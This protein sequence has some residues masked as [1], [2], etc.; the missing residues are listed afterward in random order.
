MTAYSYLS[1][2]ATY[3]HCPICKEAIPVRS[4]KPQALGLV[5]SNHLRK[6][7]I[8]TSTLTL[9]QKKDPDFLRSLYQMYQRQKK[10]TTTK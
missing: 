6:H 10:E 7:G 4:S 8:F 3:Y 2:P 1:R 5:R 9:E